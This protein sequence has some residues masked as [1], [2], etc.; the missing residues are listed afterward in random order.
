MLAPIELASVHDQT[1][2]GCA[3]A[4]NPLGGRVDDNVSTILNGSDEVASSPKGIVDLGLSISSCTD[5]REP[6]VCHSQSQALP[7]HGQPSQ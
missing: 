3:V 7:F 4:P 1:T 5:Y 2:D 6:S